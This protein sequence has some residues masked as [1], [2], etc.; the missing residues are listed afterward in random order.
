[1]EF[2]V[3]LV[4]DGNLAKGLARADELF[5]PFASKAI[6]I[7]LT[8]IEAQDAPYP[9]QPDRNRAKTFNTY[10]RGQGNYPKSAFVADT[11]EPGGFAIKA[12]MA[13][14]VRMTSQDMKSKFKTA[15]KTSGGTVQG[16]LTN[17]AT[18]SGYVLGSKEQDPKQASFHAETGWVSKEDAIEAAIPEIES[19][20]EQAVKDFL[21][22]LVGR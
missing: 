1:M 18:Y 3:R 15:V 8:A 21:T 13:G 9:P 7:S 10:V 17:S 4:D 22:A 6:A 19:A 11:K 20:Y 2:N 5:A 12:K 14:K 16:E